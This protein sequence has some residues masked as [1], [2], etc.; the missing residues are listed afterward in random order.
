V[1][2][3]MGLEDVDEFIERVLQEEQEVLMSTAKGAESDKEEREK[4][5]KCGG[6]VVS[7]HEALKSED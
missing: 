6:H 4:G 1:E 7:E 3:G 2:N 5:N